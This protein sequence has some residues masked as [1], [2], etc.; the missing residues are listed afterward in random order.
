MTDISSYWKILNVNTERLLELK[1][2]FEK[3]SGDESLQG[4]RERIL[5]G[6]EIEEVSTNIKNAGRFIKMMEWNKRLS[7]VLDNE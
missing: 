7:E 3:I 6:S 1:Q 5:I 4:K 2:K